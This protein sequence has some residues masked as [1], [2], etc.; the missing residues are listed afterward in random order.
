[1]VANTILMLTLSSIT[2]ETA[3]AHTDVPSIASSTP[4]SFSVRCKFWN[5]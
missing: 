4:N 5:N 2:F 1:M 3:T